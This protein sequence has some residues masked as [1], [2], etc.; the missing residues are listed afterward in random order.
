LVLPLASKTPNLVYSTL[1]L[2]ALAVR[3]A[4]PLLIAFFWLFFLRSNSCF[5]NREDVEKLL[6]AFFRTTEDPVPF[7]CVLG[8]VRVTPDPPL[9]VT[10]LAL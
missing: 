8:L 9:D 6:G 3:A 2:R 1:F 10:F 7:A 4:C 5:A